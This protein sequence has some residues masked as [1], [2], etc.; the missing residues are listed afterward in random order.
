MTFAVVAARTGTTDGS[1]LQQ[2][3]VGLGAPSAGDLLV[4]FCATASAGGGAVLEASAGRG[5][6]LVGEFVGTQARLAIFA[7]IALGG[8]NDS[9]SF[10]T[11][12]ACRAA[13][14][15]YQITGHG[16]AVGVGA[17]ATATSTNGDPPAASISGAAQDVLF[18]A[19]LASITSVASVAPA[20]YGTLTTQSTTTAFLSIAERNL[21]A[22]TDNPGTF[23]NASQEWLAVTVAVPS[24]AIATNARAS[25]SAAELASSV[26]PFMNVSEVAVEAISANAL[27]MLA[28]QVCVELASQNVPN[29]SLDGPSLL[30]IAT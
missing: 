6:W 16:S 30:F 20:S 28:S 7:K 3:V 22:T 9:L 14:R 8:G 13:S 1:A 23:T 18:L 26:A 21:N 12:S 19:A 17:S 11:P 5:W 10:Q 4:V 2:H 15:C 25:Q 29:D 24:V 27:T